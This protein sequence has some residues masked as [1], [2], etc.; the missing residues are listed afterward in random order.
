MGAGCKGYT[1]YHTHTWGARHTAA[2]HA[3]AL[4]ARHRRAALAVPAAEAPDGYTCLSY[5]Q[6]RE[7]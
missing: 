1:T 3:H 4:E 7:S 2:V 6:V 5:Q